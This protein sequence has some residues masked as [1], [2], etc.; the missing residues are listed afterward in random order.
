MAFAMQFP[1]TQQGK[2]NDLLN[3]LTSSPKGTA[4]VYL[5]QARFVL[6]NNPPAKDGA[7]PQYALDVMA[8]RMTLTEAYDTTQKDV[9]RP[10]NPGCHQTVRRPQVGT[11]AGDGGGWHGAPALPRGAWAFLAASRVHRPPAID[12]PALHPL[13]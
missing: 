2:R 6:R 8:G 9:V 12:L 13:C 7:F 11:V 3:D 5:S 1:N 4:K 10:R